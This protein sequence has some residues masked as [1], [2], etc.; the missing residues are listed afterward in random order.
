MT[1]LIT[2]WISY[3][4][5]AFLAG[6]L[7][8]VVG[9]FG[10]INGTV[11]TTVTQRAAGSPGHVLVVRLRMIST[12]ALWGAALVGGILRLRKGYWDLGCA[13][14]AA[15]PFPFVLLQSYGGEM[16]LR[17]YLFALPFM[18]FF[19]AALFYT[20]P[21]RTRS[22]RTPVVIGLMS[23]VLGSG[24]FVTRY[25][26]E[27]MDNF[28]PAEVA[29]VHHLYTIAKPGSLLVAVAPSLPW[30]YQDWE[31]YSYASVTGEEP[32]SIAA[33]VQKMDQR[34]YI[35]SY[36]ILTRSEIAQL[37]LND[38]WSDDQVKRL[39]KEL[40]QSQKLKLVFSNR[41]AQIFV[42]SHDAKGPGHATFAAP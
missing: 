22:W 42:L 26:N 20:T 33:I 10:H 24:F 16:L 15:A 18:A 12:L 7:N 36:L 17:V 31:K 1:V 34:K 4:A 3:A 8:M 32:G 11:S 41:D 5:A 40:A 28:T 23:I 35:D 27:R 21:G 9:N 38:G 6:H 29:A 14:L 19:V 2:V 30:M 39:E 25:G 13:L 37:E